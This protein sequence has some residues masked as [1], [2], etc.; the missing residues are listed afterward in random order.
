MQNQTARLLRIISEVLCLFEH[1]VKEGG[2]HPMYAYYIT[3][4]IK[5][6]IINNS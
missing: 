3:K 2:K 6:Q 1:T 4:K 5:T